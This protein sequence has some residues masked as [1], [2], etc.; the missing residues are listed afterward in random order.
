M[1][2][3]YFVEDFTGRPRASF[4]YVFEALPDAFGSVGFRCQIQQI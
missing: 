2:G 4:L 3:A 1:F